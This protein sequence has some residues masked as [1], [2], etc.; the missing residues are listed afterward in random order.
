MPLTELQF[1]VLFA[2][3]FGSSVED[4]GFALDTSGPAPIARKGEDEVSL[5]VA[6]DRGVEWQLNGVALVP[7]Q[8][9]GR[10]EKGQRAKAAALQ[11]LQSAIG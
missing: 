8:V 11:T 5:W 6:N 7:F 9:N 3:A 1:T 4:L 2:G 10:D